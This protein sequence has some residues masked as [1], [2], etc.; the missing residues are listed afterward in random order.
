MPGYLDDPKQS[1]AAFDDEGF[2]RT[3]DLMSFVDPAAPEKGMRFEGRH[4]EAFKLM[5]GTWVRAAELR[6][7]SQPPS[8]ADGEITAK[9]NLNYRKLLALRAA[10]VDRLYAGNDPAVIVL[11]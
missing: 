6:L 5:S 3:G 11:N 4:S 9:G 1:A 10:L 7:L 2:F 8:M